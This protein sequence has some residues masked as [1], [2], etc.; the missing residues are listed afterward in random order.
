MM[1]SQPRSRCN[2]SWKENL[3]C[4]KKQKLPTLKEDTT[5]K[6]KQG[7]LSHVFTLQKLYSIT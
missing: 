6:I 7:L 1:A 5:I 2:I 3:E 4:K